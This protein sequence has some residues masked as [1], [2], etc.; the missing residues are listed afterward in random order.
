MKTL[1]LL[2][3]VNESE[4][5]ALLQQL[6]SEK[7]RNLHKGF[8]IFIKKE[9]PTKE[10][11]YKAFFNEEY[12]KEKDVNLRNELQFLNNEIEHFIVCRE[13]KNED[14]DYYKRSILLKK[15]LDGGQAELFH[16]E[17]N[18][19]IKDALKYETSHR[20]SHFLELKCKWNAKH[21]ALWDS[22]W[23]ELIEELSTNTDRVK[24][25][26]LQMYY[27]FLANVN[28]IT[29]N[30][31]LNHDPNDPRLA[32][33]KFFKSEITYL[34]ET[35][36]LEPF[37]I[38]SYYDM[39]TTNFDLDLKDRIKLTNQAIKLLKNEHRYLFSVYDKLA[40][41]YFYELQD[42]QKFYETRKKGYH[43]YL[44][45]IDYPQAKPL[46]NAIVNYMWACIVVEKYQEC[47]SIFEKHK[48]FIEE[49]NAG[50]NNFRLRMIVAYLHLEKFE[51][52]YDLLPTD[53]INYPIIDKYFGRLLY[54]I[55]NIELKRTEL[56]KTELNNS[57]KALSIT[58]FEP[59]FEKAFKGLKVFLEFRQSKTVDKKKILEYFQSE[60]AYIVSIKTYIQKTLPQK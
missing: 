38:S 6:K 47:I 24:N 31:K 1:Q 32:K 11:L 40:Y 42:Y 20:L 29:T 55:V 9:N 16:R 50:Y 5:Q 23:F 25:Y 53:F 27:K 30:L 14:N 17:C 28:R 12:K 34:K 52:A 36:T 15:Y 3:L 35:S 37:T 2:K 54:C 33:L 59:D 43:A 39:L 49:N 13:I 26:S 19:A 58:P 44:S 45:I 8:S 60:N 10:E 41:Y 57:L 48:S 51:R 21:H 56:A 7:Q 46:S 4:K 18:A 22:Q